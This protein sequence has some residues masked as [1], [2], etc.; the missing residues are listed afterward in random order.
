M[1][2]G[3]DRTAPRNKYLTFADAKVTG[4]VPEDLWCSCALMDSG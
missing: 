1:A 2:A 3:K 4:T